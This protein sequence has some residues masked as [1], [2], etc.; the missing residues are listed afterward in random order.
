MKKK[1]PSKVGCFSKIE[2]IFITALAAQ[3]AKKGE[4]MFSNLN[5]RPTVYKTG[6]SHTQF[7]R[8]KAGVSPIYLQEHS[9]TTDIRVCSKLEFQHSHF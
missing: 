1:T 9:A 8:R 5:Y 2:E 6:V 7:P 4:F 3:A